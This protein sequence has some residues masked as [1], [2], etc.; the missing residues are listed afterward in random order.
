MGVIVAAWAVSAGTVLP[1]AA[2]T[3]PRGYL[4]K[5]KAREMWKVADGSGVTVAVIDS[6]VK[7]VPGLEGRVLPGISFMEP[8]FE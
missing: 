3:D 5:M 1:A 4:T 2:D 7:D 8:P 6:G